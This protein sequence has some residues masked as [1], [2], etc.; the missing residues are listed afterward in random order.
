MRATAVS[1]PTQ[2]LVLSNREPYQHERGPDGRLHVLRCS[3]GV[4][5]AVEPLLLENSGVWVAAGSGEV[6]RQTAIN[7]DGVEVPPESPRYRLRRVWLT[8]A[9]VKGYYYGFAN[10]GLWPLCHR[11]SVTP[12]FYAQDFGMYELVNRRFAEAVAEEARVPAP[13][14]LVQDYHFALAP[15]MIRRQLPLS[16]IATF[17][18]IPWPSPQAFRRCPWSNTL[19][20]GLLG[21]SLVG[22][23]TPLDRD[24]FLRCAEQFTDVDVDNTVV[25]WKGR[26][27]QLGVYPASVEWPDRTV[28]RTPSIADCRAQVRRQ[29]GVSED[30]VVGLG[31][32][33]LDYTKGL[34][35]KLLAVERLLECRPDL[36]QRFVFVQIAQPSREA[37]PAY[38]QTR[39]RLFAVAERINQRFSGGVAPVVLLPTHHDQLA[40]TRYMRGAD[41]C[42]VGSLHDGMNLVSKEFVAARDDDRGVLVLSAFA[43]ASHE[44]RD[45]LIVNPYD[46]EQSAR[47][48]A[49]AIEMPVLQQRFRMRRLRRAVASFDARA[50]AT[51]LLTDVAHDSDAPARRMAPYRSAAL[52][53]VPVS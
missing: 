22:F 7:A 4:V 5:N 44:L 18:H 34:E 30:T 28:A 41:F 10:S 50:W 37:L 8:D 51:R 13:V 38:R 23:Q 11:T 43:G 39:E 17:W 32:D 48:L 6:D 2:I 49:A 3:S 29:L 31:V 40:I 15:A 25:Q 9:E 12:T 1:P 24:S 36:R 33:R 21:S 42:Y 45:A 20:E 26:R 19:L 35:E 53:E 16:R 52:V 14:V 46:R 27:V 47:S